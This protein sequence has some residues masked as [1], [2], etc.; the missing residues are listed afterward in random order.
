ME[1]EEVAK[2]EKIF[3]RQRSRIQW[4][5]NDD[6]NMK[7]FHRMA[8]THK[9]INTIESLNINGEL[10]SEPAEIKNSIVGFYHHLYKEVEN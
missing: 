3:W 4:I 5:K 2:N 8:T 6:K 7:Y 9:R 1:Y 10:F